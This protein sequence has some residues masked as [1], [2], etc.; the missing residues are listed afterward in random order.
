MRKDLSEKNYT[1]FSEGNKE[2]QRLHHMPTSCQ[3]LP[4]GSIRNLD[5]HLGNYIE[6]NRLDIGTKS[7]LLLL[8]LDEMYLP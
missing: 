8:L 2:I 5:M 6:E 1:R 7:F 3:H 4:W